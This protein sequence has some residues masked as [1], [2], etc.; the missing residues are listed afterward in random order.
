MSIH[1]IV[2][3]V[4]RGFQALF[5][6]VVLGISVTLIRGIH[7]GNIPISIGFAAFVGG[8]SVLMAV[9]SALL[10]WKDVLQGRIAAAI[11]AFVALLNLA[12]GIVRYAN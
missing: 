10:S 11:D 8:F 4:L 2:N 5:G 12:G 9:V 6:I 3:F 1:P 7:W